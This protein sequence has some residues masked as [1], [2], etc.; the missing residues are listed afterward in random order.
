MLFCFVLLRVCVC[1]RERRGL[2]G[3]M[4]PSDKG[5][6]KP[7]DVRFNPWT[8]YG[9]Q[10]V[11]LL[12]KWDNESCS[13]L[14]CADPATGF[15][16]QKKQP[17]PRVRSTRTREQAGGS[18]DLSPTRQVGEL[19]PHRRM[20]SRRCKTRTGTRLRPCSSHTRPTS[21]TRSGEESCSRK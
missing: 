5:W 18:K 2:A 15:A 4:P 8:K 3:R 7:D 12:E 1:V 21:E 11:M 16:L 14:G 20:C 19:R 6:H 17:A 13:Q 10:G 9:R